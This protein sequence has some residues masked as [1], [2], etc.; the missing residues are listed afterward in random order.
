MRPE[1][2]ETAFRQFRGTLT[3]EEETAMRS[4]FPQYLFFRNEYEDD[5]WNI[6]DGPVR[7]CTCTAC[8]ETFEAVRGNY[9]RGRL[10]NEECDCPCCGRRVTGKAVHKFRYEMNS[11]QSWIKTAVA[12]AGEDGALLIEAG[13]ARRR[14]N[15]DELG[16][17]L[18]WFPEKRYY[19]APGT[20]QM[21]EHRVMTWACEPAER[22]VRW[23]PVE[24][25]R[26]PFQPNLMGAYS[27]YY[28]DY[29]VIGLDE[30]LRGSALRYSQIMDFYEYEYAA[31]LCEL[32]TARWMVKYLA[33][34]ALH[35]QIEMAVKFG[36]TDAVRELTE[37]GRKNAR[38]LDWNGRTPEQFLRMSRAEARLFLKAE[39]EFRDLKEWRNTAGK[40]T[41]S[42]YM[43]LVNDVGT[44]ANLREVG[45]C[46][47]LAGC[48]LEKGVRYVLGQMPRCARNAPPLQVIIRTWKD[49]L[50]MAR[51]L[52]YDLKEPTVAL[53]RDL[54][55]RHDAAA[56]LQRL[57]AGEA[58]EKRYGKRRRMLEKLYAFT[59][60]D[61][62]IVIPR[63]S[64]E[65]VTEGKTLHHC[66]GGYAAR[67]VAGST[68]ILFLRHRRRPER[69]FL[70]IELK[71]ERGR[72]GI[73]QIHGY[74]NE[75][76]GIGERRG[77][78][79]KE[80]Y[81]WFLSAWLGWV[82]EGSQRDKAGRPVIKE[83]EM[84]A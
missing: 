11:L 60:D 38:L 75:G 32:D 82:N 76:Y 21:W 65:I 50:T 78:D 17:E 40:M 63:S 34:Y 74:K 8:G 19:L 12:Y 30:A 51:S 13:N 84:S 53:P 2:R 47:R 24:T 41:F 14:F 61:L 46:A 33:W 48:G 54:K 18:D 15:W 68:T 71:E 42:D 39:M 27:Y 56:E 83:K 59:M 67:H 77:A 31:K 37:H 81:G 36:F 7:L 80:K 29:N 73:R 4:T 16:G 10:H 55:D 72:I 57:R 44:T 79:P 28:G 22:D 52:D 45:D 9:A 43:T 26:E 66:V 25:I 49:Y 23:F 6:S 35:P 5:G 3:G 62:S 20:V 1:E 58:E 70:T 64:E 69:S